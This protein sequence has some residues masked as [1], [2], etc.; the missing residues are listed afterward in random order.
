[1]LNLIHLYIR[2]FPNG[3]NWCSIMYYF[4]SCSTHFFPYEET[5]HCLTYFASNIRVLRFGFER[6]CWECLKHGC[7]R[8]SLKNLNSF[9]SSVECNVPLMS[10]ELLKTTGNI[11]L[12]NHS[13]WRCESRSLMFCIFGILP[14]RIF[15]NISL[16]YQHISRLSGS[17]Q[18][19]VQLCD[20]SAIPQLY[21]R[22]ESLR[23]FCR[24]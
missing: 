2:K 3:R 21:H 7:C 19:A 23:V 24:S 20:L 5:W 13:D 9:R 15:G 16:F 4:P 10:S 6:C 8:R 22:K 12:I 1:M 17:A 11:V 14:S 18:V